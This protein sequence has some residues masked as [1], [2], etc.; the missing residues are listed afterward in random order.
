MMNKVYYF[1]ALVLNFSTQ[2]TFAEVSFN[3]FNLS[4]SATA[5]TPQGSTSIGV[6]VNGVVNVGS[7]GFCQI[8][9]GGSK[10]ECSTSPAL[11]K[12]FFKRNVRPTDYMLSHYEWHQNIVKTKINRGRKMI[13]NLMALPPQFQGYDL[14]NPWEFESRGEIL[15]QL[16]FENDKSQVINLKIV[17]DGGDLKKWCTAIDSYGYPSSDVPPCHWR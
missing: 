4:I 11:D 17:T 10:I 14:G 7:N 13:L 3:H 9:V 5:S 8:E 6:P 15:Q 16:L 2:T 12:V 1:V